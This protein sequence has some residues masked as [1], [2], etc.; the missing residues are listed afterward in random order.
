M[1]TELSKDYK[2]TLAQETKPYVIEFYTPWCGVCKQVM[3]LFAE[4]AAEYKD[5]YSFYK[6]NVDEIVELAKDY[7][8]KSVPTLLFIKNGEVKNKHHGYITK[9]DIIAKLKESFK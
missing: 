1:I 7:N 3:P 2:K 6:V 9:E 4:V 8:I 5:K